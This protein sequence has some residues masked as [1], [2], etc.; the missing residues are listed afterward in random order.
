MLPKRTFAHLEAAK[1]II[2]HSVS[3]SQSFTLSPTKPTFANLAAT[4][5]IFAHLQ[6]LR[7]DQ[8]D[9]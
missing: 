8:N 1:S 2:E 9:L 7:Q 6:Q 5:P 3:L 4:N